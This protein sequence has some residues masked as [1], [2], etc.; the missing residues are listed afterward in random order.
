M[1]LLLDCQQLQLVG[2]ARLDMINIVVFVQYVVSP[3][4]CLTEL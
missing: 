2:R 3:P 1:V 4:W